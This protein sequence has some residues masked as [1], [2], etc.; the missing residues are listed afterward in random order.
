MT[1]IMDM[2]FHRRMRST[3]DRRSQDLAAL[4]GALAAR[5]ALSPTALAMTQFIETAEDARHP[6]VSPFVPL[7]Q[8]T[9]TAQAVSSFHPGVS[10][11]LFSLCQSS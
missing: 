1:L 9:G 2:G 7:G 4:L 5:Q 6:A 8:S 11:S 10:A 3:G